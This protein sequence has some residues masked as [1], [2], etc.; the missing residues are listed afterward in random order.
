MGDNFT[1][2]AD[3]SYDNLMWVTTSQPGMESIMTY[4]M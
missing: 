3:A 2:P 4:E 1:E